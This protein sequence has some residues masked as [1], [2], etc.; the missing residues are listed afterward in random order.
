MK[1]ISLFILFIT[2]TIAG[3]SQQKLR[4]NG[5]AN[6]V[7]DDSYDS[8]YDAPV[9]V[10]PPSVYFGFGSDRCYPRSYGYRDWDRRHYS[11]RGRDYRHAVQRLRGHC[12]A[13]HG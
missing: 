7:F 11:Y 12:C 13:V 2:I 1:R 10:S 6:Y 4:L 3:S 5:Y 9:V 8:Y